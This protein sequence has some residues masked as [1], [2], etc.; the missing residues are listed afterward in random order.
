MVLV[1]TENFKHDWLRFQ[2]LNEGLGDRHGDILNMIE[3]KWLTRIL[4][5]FSAK[6]FFV[7][8]NE[9]ELTENV[10]ILGGDTGTLQDGDTKSE[11]L[12]DQ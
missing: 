11:F 7:S 10:R 4:N 8:V 2:I 3:S 1:M 6:C 9:V 12:A 5:R